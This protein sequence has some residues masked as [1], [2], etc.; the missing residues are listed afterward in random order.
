LGGGVITI[1]HRVVWERG[2]SNQKGLIEGVGRYGSFL[3][4]VGSLLKKKEISLPVSV[5]GI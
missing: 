5:V 1:S 2:G 3:G 4:P